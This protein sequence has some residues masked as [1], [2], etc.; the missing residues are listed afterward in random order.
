MPINPHDLYGLGAAGS[1]IAAELRRQGTDRAVLIH[2]DA[3]GMVYLLDR[4][5]GQILSAQA[6]VDVNAT[7]GVDLPSGALRR[8]RAKA[9]H[10]SSTT[11]DV[12]PAWPGATGGT[13]QAAYAPRTG[14]LYL[15]VNRLCMDIEARAVSFMPGTPYIGANLRIKAP[16]DNNRRG[17]LLA[18][19]VVAG[20]PAWQADESLPIE[21]GVLLTAGGVVFY[22]TL[23]GWFKA[24]DARSGKLLWQFHAASAIVGQPISFQRKDGRQY[25]AVLAGM[26]GA[27]GAV[28]QEE[29]DIRDA[30]AARGYAN[31]IHGLRPAAN[32][33]ML[34]IFSLP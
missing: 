8:N 21:S 18:W 28:A 26:G 5:S 14:L 15:P 2:P 12:C 29:I 34:Y 9:T 16:H 27:A 24:V 4:S 6:F 19:S 17:A 11:R 32:H 33:G 13:A 10:V 1:L 30:T 23:D 25:I 7:E 31:A 3:N 22:G 20:K